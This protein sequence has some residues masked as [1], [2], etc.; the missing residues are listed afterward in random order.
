MKHIKTF[1]RFLN[2]SAATLDDVE[3]LGEDW[4]AETV[5]P[6]DLK[7]MA[8]Q[9]DEVSK[10]V[11]DSAKKIGPFKLM[12]LTCKSWVSD[13]DGLKDAGLRWPLFLKILKSEG[14]QYEEKK[15]GSDH[16]VVFY[17]K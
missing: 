9:T 8:S 17:S 15:M 2:E 16:V 14:F 4:N 11:V 7:K 6:D 1:D 3:S 10:F 5:E 12:Y 13:D